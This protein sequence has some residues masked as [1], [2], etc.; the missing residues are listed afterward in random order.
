MGWFDENV[1]KPVK[2]TASSAGNAATTW[3][4]GGLD[5]LGGGGVAGIGNLF[6]GITGQNAADSAEKAARIQ[7]A[8]QREAL[9]YLKET[10]AIPQAFREGAL[11]NIG[12]YYGIGIDPETGEFMQID[13]TMPT[14]Q[15]QIDQAMASPLYSSIM[16]GREAGE[17]AL[18]RRGAM[19]SGLRGG[20]TTSS[21]INYN[22]DLQNEALMSSFQDQRNQ[23]AQRLSG[24][25]SLAQIPS[26]VNAIANTQMGIGQTQAQGVTAAAQARQDAMG[27]LFGLGGQLGS[28]ALMAPV[29]SDVRLKDDIVRI[30]ETSHPYIDKYEW[31]WRKESGKK[32]REKGFLAQEIE[33]V[34]P[35]FV[36]TGADG[37]KRIMK[38][39][40]EQRLEDLKNGE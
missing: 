12:A 25:G 11:T 35:E 19:G 34:W 15:Q 28:A 39:K 10:E 33:S 13:A 20:A 16:S 17:E 14:Q 30:S 37:Y 32:G 29:V 36:V 9:E 2:N 22:T 18:A 31:E 26:N 40:I 5:L 24:L 7:A 6:G 4:T 38:D 1:V 23:E 21:L 3:S 27:N 8:A